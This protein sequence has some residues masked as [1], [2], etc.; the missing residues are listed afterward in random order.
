MPAGPVGGVPWERIE[1]TLADGERLSLLA[2]PDAAVQGLRH[3]LLETPAIARTRDGS[4]RMSLT[5]T[6]DR[7]PRPDESD[8]RDRV[9]S[10]HLMVELQ[11]LPDAPSMAALSGTGG[12]DHRT[13]FP[14]SVTFA[15]ISES[16]ALGSESVSGGSTQGALG[17]SLDRENAIAVLDALEG[18]ASGP[19]LT[20][21]AT[22]RVGRKPTPPMTLE[23][24]LLTVH[25]RLAA[26][27]DATRELYETDIRNYVALMIAD[28]T[29]RTDP[30]VQAGDESGVASAVLD[31]FVRTLLMILTRVAEADDATPSDRTRLLGQRFT[32]DR[33]PHGPMPINVRL[34]AD[35]SASESSV[36]HIETTARDVFRRASLTAA[37]TGHVHFVVNDGRGPVPLVRRSRQRGAARASKSNVTAL[38]VSGNRLTTLS[39]AVRPALH[40]NVSTHSVLA[41]QPSV[42]PELLTQIQNVVVASP[43]NRPQSLPIVGTGKEALWPD[44]VDTK[45]FWYAPSFSLVEPAVPVDPTGDDFRFE[46]VRRGHDQQGRAVLEATVTITLRR[47]MPATASNAMKSHPGATAKPVVMKNVSAVLD[48]PFRDETGVARIQHVRSSDVNINGDRIR[49]RFT[50]MND[51]VRVAYGVLAVAGFQSSAAQVSVAF[52]YDAYQ[53]L[54]R[55]QKYSIQYG[56]KEVGIPVFRGGSREMTAHSEASGA[57]IDARTGAVRY[58]RTVVGFEPDTPSRDLTGSRSGARPTAINAASLTIARPPTVSLNPVIR[59]QVLMTPAWEAALKPTKYTK[60]TRFHRQ[61]TPVLF[62]CGQFGTLYVERNGD[63][64][65]TVGCQDAFSLGQTERRL[66]DDVSLP[67]E[68]D[69][70]RV[71]R[72]RQSPGRF[73]VIPETYLIARYEPDQPERAYRPTVLLY[74]TIDVDDLAASRCVV[75]ASLIPDVTRAQRERLLA[76]LRDAE[77]ADPTLDYLTEIEADVEFDWAIP[78]GTSSGVLRLD[79]EAT[80]VPHG[81]ETSLATDALGVPQLQAILLGSG[82]TG[83]AQFTLSD[84]TTIS[85]TLRLDLRQIAGPWQAGAVDAV[86][87]RGGGASVTNRTEAVANVSDLLLIY[88]E[89]Q[90]SSQVESMPVNL[91]LEPGAGEMVELDADATRIVAVS[92]LESSAASLDEVRSFIE[93]ISLNVTLL[94]RIDFEA[95]GIERIRIIASIEGVDESREVELLPDSDPVASISF[96]LPLTAYLADP[97]LVISATVIDVDGESQN[98]D[99]IEWSLGTQGYIVHITKSLLGLTPA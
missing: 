96:L 69:G 70:F 44:R 72:S 48:L 52:Q 75:M 15:A 31:D 61:S 81:F 49:V 59:P 57:T 65:H 7:Q 45:R 84:D 56:R 85:T 8:L 40:A 22:F 73:L 36:V 29:I 91:R 17:L 68:F 13:L 25:R 98:R 19:R 12:Y 58:G 10:A 90:G 3:V 99:A 35:S 18:R 11:I 37:S 74:S 9:T 2:R 23:T 43:T 64:V 6:L 62:P 24:D 60:N 79:A 78:T 38:A 63:A 30:P 39:T 33:E 46:F 34:R 5:V 82:I 47:I 27:V 14:S 97:S 4:P 20:A 32:L 80:R 53:K 89:S 67:A 21:A 51:W 54:S 77:H 66:Y 50:L 41:T 55:G 42:R 86:V 88:D 76:H 1:S 71:K 87:N 93:D 26:T 94:S 83:S 28:G 92:E 16:E 95:S